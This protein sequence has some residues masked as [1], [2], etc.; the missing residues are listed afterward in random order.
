MAPLASA[1][2]MPTMTDGVGADLIGSWFG[3]G[4]ERG[5]ALLFT[6]AGLVGVAVTLIARTSRSFRRL[7]ATVDTPAPT[8]EV[9]PCWLV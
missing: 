6:L 5:L 1:V 2:F 3:T 9:T 7:D 8:R 4:P